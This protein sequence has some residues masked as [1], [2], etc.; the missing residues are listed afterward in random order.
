MIAP[1]EDAHTGIHSEALDRTVRILRHDPVLEG[2]D[3]FDSSREKLEAIFDGALEVIRTG[4]VQGELHSFCNGHLMHGLLPGGLVYLRLDGEGGYSDQPGFAAQLETME[5]ALD[6]IFPVAHNA[7]GLILDVRK[8][9]GGSDILSLAMASRLTGRDYFA[10]TKVAR[11]DP[12]DPDIF[13]PGQERMVRAAS[14]PAFKGPVVL[15]TGPYTISAG[16]TL[17][18][19]LMGR[20]PHIVRVGE[21]TQGVFSDTLGRVLPNGWKIWLPNELFLTRGGLYFDGPGILPDVSVPVF[22]QSDIDAG[23]DPALEKAIDILT[24]R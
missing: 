12:D 19:A 18:Q 13:T 3:S 6:E 17:T 21:P 10:Y 7:Q 9:Y 1:L 20:K 15:L 23:K 16:E 2:T 11:S 24:A 4:Y 14:G 22:R 8:N 5:S